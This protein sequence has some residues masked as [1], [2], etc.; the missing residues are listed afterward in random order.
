MSV[1]F[2]VQAK[3]LDEAEYGKYLEVIDDV[4]SKYNGEYLA[5]ED[6]PF[7]LEGSWDYSRIVVIRFDNRADFD[8]WY[9]SDDYQGI[10]KHRLDGADC[11]TLLINGI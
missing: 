8:A 1:Y 11:D 6:H 3:I 10:I 5:V 2:I 4:F 9:Y 7:I